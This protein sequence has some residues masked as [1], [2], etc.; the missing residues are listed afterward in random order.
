[1]CWPG[2]RSASLLLTALPNAAG[3]IAGAAVIAL[4]IAFLTPAIFAAILG[5]VPAHERGA[6]AGTATI[7]IALGFGG[8][9]FL[10]G[11]VAAAGGTSLAF[12]VG[13]GLTAAGKGAA[14]TSATGPSD[15]DRG[16]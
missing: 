1:M 10:L 8:G 4:G 12:T 16:T 6:A 2:A 11:S 13:A 15:P 9:S 7:F 5:A 3:L 14:D